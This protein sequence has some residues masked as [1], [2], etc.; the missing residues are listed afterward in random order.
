M[1]IQIGNGGLET[2]GV[3]EKW[4]ISVDLAWRNVS[5]Q[6]EGEEKIEDRGGGEL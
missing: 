6:Q 5:M 1:S 2:G 3:A 4:E